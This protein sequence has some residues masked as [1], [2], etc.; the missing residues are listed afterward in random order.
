MRQIIQMFSFDVKLN[1]KSF[2]AGY[3][4]IVPMAILL[5]LRT[6]IPSVESATI[7]FAIVTK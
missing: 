4:L 5:V 6:F 3:M 1:T 7:N 2:M